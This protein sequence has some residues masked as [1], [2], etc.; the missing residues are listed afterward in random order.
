M[1]LNFSQSGISGGLKRLARENAANG[2]AISILDD[3]VFK[4]MLTTNTDDARNAL[5][6]LLTACIGREVSAVSIA[7][8]ELIP[9]YLGA[10]TSRLDVHVIFNDGE[11]ADLEMQMEKTNDDLGKRAINYSAMLLA[12]QPK[13]GKLHKETKRIYQIFFLD[14][15]LKPESAKIPRRY[16]Y[17]EEEEHDRL[18]DVTEII[19][20][21]MPRLEEQIRNFL[22]KETNINNLRDD[23]KWCIF[24]KYRH[25]DWAKEIIDKLCQ[26]EAGIMSAEKTIKLVDRRYR[27][28]A[29]NMAMMKNSMDR[30]SDIDYAHREGRREGEAIGLEKGE[31]IGLAK[32]ESIGLA[33]GEV[34]AYKN[35]LET[36]AKMKA[37]G[38]SVEKIMEFTNLS[39][40]EILRL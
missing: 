17:M 11:S 14:Y 26:E 5:K 23:E 31:V 3:A 18:S 28:F 38:L 40:D 30:A 39:Y 8:N 7:N 37:S 16:F 25:I 15:I 4:A 13:K 27:K 1:R 35:M 34:I 21:E 10:K 12:G 29:R 9:A 2:G 22:K 36:A 20:Y 33:K 32:G 6:S 24:M 19:F